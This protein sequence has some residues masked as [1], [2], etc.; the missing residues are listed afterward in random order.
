MSDQRTHVVYT[1][2]LLRRGHGY[3]LWIPEPD[4][5][6]P[7]AYRDKGVSVGDLDIL[8][9][10]GGFDFL[11][12]ICVDAD[13]P[14]NQGHV[15]P[16]FEPLRFPQRD[17]IRKVMSLHRKNSSVTSAHVSTT[18]ISVEGSAEV[19]S[20]VTGGGRFEFST[21]KAEAAIL[22]L[23]DGGNIY[24]NSLDHLARQAP[25]GS[26]YL[27]T[28][29]DK[30][31]SWTAAVSRPSESHTIS[32]KFVIGPIMEGG[33]ALQTSWST[34][35]G[36]DTRI[37]PD[38]PD[39]MPQQENQCVFMRGFTISVRENNL[40]KKMFGP[41]LIKAIG[42]SMKDAAPSFSSRSPYSSYHDNIA[43]PSSSGSH[44]LRVLRRISTFLITG[45]SDKD[46]KSDDHIELTYLPSGSTELLNPS[47]ESSASRYS[48]AVTHDEDWMEVT[49]EYPPDQWLTSN[50]YEK[51]S[52]E[53]LVLD[54][55]QPLT[56]K[57][58]PLKSPLRAPYTAQA[59]DVCRR[60]PNA[61]G[62]GLSVDRVRHR[63][64][65]T[66]AL[67]LARVSAVPKLAPDANLSK[68]GANSKR[69]RI[70]ANAV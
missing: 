34:H 47:V 66:T 1:K 15:P 68:L 8:T 26:L 39:S 43:G 45:S 62:S 53:S 70:L 24:V 7:D 22:M 63:S 18:E 44:H 28:G 38:H 36:A 13:D 37:Y 55:G 21:S 49:K 6:L 46:V 20:F 30:A 42:G 2:L 19:S 50:F 27:V 59:C 41:V 69:T 16:Q 52:A 17:P 12:N 48:V 61:T 64:A 32:V 40:M 57:A 5:S 10:D 4:Y 51:K 25:N 58:G 56:K 14:V 67:G 3:P 60:K 54:G 29:C 31:R 9:E 35:I 23:P 65:L 11:F 33:I